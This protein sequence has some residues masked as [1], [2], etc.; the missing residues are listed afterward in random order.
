MKRAKLLFFFFVAELISNGTDVTWRAIYK[1]V[2]PTGQTGA[3][4]VCYSNDR[5]R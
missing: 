4:L 3:A 2:E 1:D 5:L